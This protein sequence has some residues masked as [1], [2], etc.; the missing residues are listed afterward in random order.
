MDWRARIEVLAAEQG[1]PLVRFARVGRIPEAERVQAWIDAGMH[2]DMDW[3]ERTAEV[4]LDPRVRLPDAK[5]AIVLGVPHGGPVPPDPGGWTG[6]VARYAWGRDYHNLVGK[7]LKKLQRALRELGVHGFGGVDTAPLVERSWASASG[8]GFLGKNAMIF[9]PG[10]TSFLFLAVI[11]VDVDVEPDAP[12][13]RD[14]C[15]SC[16]RCLVACP[17]DAFRG[18]RVLDARRCVSYWTIEAEDLAPPDLLPG[19]GRWVFG[20]DGCQDVCPH[21]HDAPAPADTDLLPRHA[22][23]DLAEVLATPDDALM[24]RFTGTPL[25]RPGAAGLKRN[26]LVVLGNLGDPNAVGLVTSGMT[27][28]SPVV[29]RAAA[30]ALE[31]LAS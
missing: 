14:H 8:L 22:W 30:W 3:L 13:A 16:R 2:A 4:R 6:R 9:L 18:P 11:V 20:C 21:N 24:A 29:Q 10:Q 5:T 31:R 25:R 19:F 27:H 1:F 15:G 17:T 7:R 23:L 28:P 26:A 12:I